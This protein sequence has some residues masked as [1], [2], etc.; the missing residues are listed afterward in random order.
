MMKKSLTTLLLVFLIAGFAQAQYLSTISGT[1][2]FD[3][4]PMVDFGIAI[5]IPDTEGVALKW[6]DSNGMYFTRAYIGTYNLAI[7]DTFLY[8]PLSYDVKIDSLGQHEICDFELTLREQDAAVTGNVSFDGFGVET[9]VYFLKISDDVD[10]NDF[11]QVE[12]HFEVPAIAKKWASYSTDSDANGDLSLG[13]LYG[14]YV[15]YIESA[16]LTLAHWGAIN[17]QKDMTLDPIILKEKKFLSGTVLNA[18]QYDYVQILA[19]SL[20]SG[21]PYT[22]VPNMETGE[23]TIEVAPGTYIVRC[24][25]FIEEHLYMVYYDS[26]YTSQEAEQIEVQ[27]DVSGIDFNLPTPYVRHF[28]VSGTVTSANSGL[29]L[30]GA[31]LTFVSYNIYANLYN[32]YWVETDEKGDYLVEGTT[33]MEEDSLYGFAYA[34]NFFGEFYD[35]KMTHIDADPIVYHADENVTGIDFALDTLNTENC[36]SISGFITDED[37]EIVGQG[38]ITAFTNATTVGVVTA[39]IDTNGNYAF[40]AVF[41][42]NSTVYLQAWGGYDY[43]PMY[44]DNKDTW[45]DADPIT[46][47]Q[48]ITGINFVLKKK[49]PRRFPLAEIRGYVQISGNPKIAESLQGAVAYVRAEGATEWTD[50]DFVDASGNFTLPAETNGNYEVMLTAKGCEDQTIQVTIDG[51]T[52]DANVTLNPTGIEDGKDIIVRNHQLFRAYPNPF[53]PTTTI[54]VEMAKTAEASLVIYNVMGQKVKTLHS[55]SLEKGTKNFKWNGTDNAGKQV[56]SGLYFYQLKTRNNMQTKSVI[57]LK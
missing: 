24:Q 3:S 53:N 42:A 57:F 37:K 14:K 52:G 11:T 55:G 15:L 50:A 32:T 16:E 10:L 47:T 20:N 2:T 40:D 12:T 54:R 34:E 17:V 45:E 35:N 49:A 36:F 4:Q 13:M 41:P 21:R 51:L 23:Y 28:T 31:N 8:N 39:Q 22:A 25:A 26:V 30:A 7:V 19:H 18:D 27:D 1:V 33:I 6:T 38:Q 56:A 9:T 43:L 48:D 44:Y 5:T 46:I 29:A